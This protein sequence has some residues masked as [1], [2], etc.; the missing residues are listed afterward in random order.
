MLEVPGQVENAPSQPRQ[1]QVNRHGPGQDTDLSR[2]GRLVGQV[3]LLLLALY[4]GIPAV[5]VVLDR[6]LKVLAYADCA[7]SL[8]WC[9][10]QNSV[11][12]P[13]LLGLAARFRPCLLCS[14]A[15]SSAAYRSWLSSSSLSRISCRTAA[16]MV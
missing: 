2:V 13:A 7:V 8:L 15:R 14:P 3:V 16:P 5:R 9:D 12:S 4:A 11:V 10:H 6:Q 1:Q